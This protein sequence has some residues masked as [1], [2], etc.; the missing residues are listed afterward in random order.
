MAVAS[1]N[2]IHNVRIRTFFMGGK[3]RI[4]ALLSYTV[5]PSENVHAYKLQV[6]RD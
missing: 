4:D 5:Q 2:Q 1:D 3:R 6:F